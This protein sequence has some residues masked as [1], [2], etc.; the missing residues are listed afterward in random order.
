QSGGPDRSFDLAAAY[1]ERELHR[2]TYRGEW[3]S[4]DPEPVIPRLERVRIAEGDR[5]H[6][7]TTVGVPDGVSHYT[8]RLEVGDRSP[9]VRTVES[10]DDE[11]E[12]DWTIESG[13]VALDGPTGES[14]RLAHHDRVDLFVRLVEPDGSTLTYHQSM[15]VRSADGNVSVVWPPERRVCRL[16]DRCGTA[17]T[18]LPE[19]PD[20]FIDGVSFEVALEGQR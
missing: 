19:H 20:E 1:P 17:G 3:R 4:V 6:G 14:I 11:A 8:V 15:D 2:F 13:T 9:V 16:T 10:V 18:Y 7:R 5:L 12:V